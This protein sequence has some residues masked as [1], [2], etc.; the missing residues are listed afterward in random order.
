MM[1]TISSYVRRVGRFLRRLTREPGLR[2]P[3]RIAVSFLSG[4]CLSAASLLHQA[5]PLVPGALCSGPGGWMSVPAALGAAAGYRLFWGQAGLQGIVWTAAGLALSTAL[6]QRRFIRQSP[7][8]MPALTALV[9]AVT[10]L[11]FQAWLHDETGLGMYLLRIALAFGSTWLLTQAR[12]G[13]AVARWGAA[14]MAVLALAQMAPLPFLDLGAVAAGIVSVTMPFP[15]VV[16]AGLALDLAQITRV[17]MAA[18]LCL[19]FLLRLIPGMPKWSA[20]VAPAAAYLLV[21]R[22]CEIWDLAP[23]VGLLL[24]SVGGSLL[25][26]RAAPVPRRGP[27]GVAQVRLEMAAQVLAQSEQLLREVCQP[28]LDEQVLIIKAA[29]RACG[30]CPCRREC[31]QTEQARCLSPQLLHRPL[32][33]VEDLTLRCKKRG[34][35]LVELRR[36]QDQYRMLRADRDRRREY[37]G[38]L[39][40]QYRFLTEYL[41]ELADLLPRRTEQA[42]QRFQPEVAVCSAGR[43]TRNGD[44]CSWFAGPQLQYYLLLCDGMGTGAEASREAG[45]CVDMLRRLLTAGYPAEYALRSIN[46]LCVLRGVPGAVS[47]DLARIDLAS[48]K[49]MIYKWGAAPSWLLLPSGV[50]QVGTAGTPPGL[51]VT[52]ARETVER[53]SLRRGETLVL[54]SDGVAGE[55]AVASVQHRQTLSPGELAAAILEAGRGDG[56]DDATAAVIRLQ[57]VTTSAS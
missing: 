19:A 33:T 10:G 6:G 24:G 30:T 43:E 15:A 4:F 44:R 29:E 12:Q 51:D 11:L 9:T 46:S 49:T 1:I 55:E 40:Q 32:L 21:M 52:R 39:L 23:L 45:G 54:L 36:C 38:A 8:L 28:P 26:G 25:P 35:L 57:P 56:A 53:L 17:S 42:K 41:Q 7:V 18:V 3:M 48:G 31:D 27:T 14:A 22:L 5:L 47:I 2:L 20:A 13:D 16:L 34:R 50:E 37:H